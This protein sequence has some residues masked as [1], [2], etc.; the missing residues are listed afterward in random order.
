MRIGQRHHQ[1]EIEFALLGYLF[2]RP[3]HA[4]EIHRHLV[5]HGGLGLV[6]NLNQSRLYAQLAQLER[7]GFVAAT[8]QPQVGRPARRVLRLT[9]TGRDTF[10]AW[11]HTPVAGARHIRMEFMAK[12]VFLHVLN[13]D[14][15]AVLLERQ[16]VLAQEWLT[17]LQS[18]L[19]ALQDTQSFEWMV[20]QF[21]IG[22]VQATL[23]WIATCT[24]A[25]AKT[26][27]D[28]TTS[29]HNSP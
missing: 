4:Y 8:T 21:R 29:T 26:S 6:W 9:E 7:R 22:Q 13:P 23:G 18:Q 16:R 14:E 11:L 15:A 19:S 5:S 25:L 1:N 27:M 2:Q 3:M 12:L 24:S 17:A 20:F 10:L 28:A